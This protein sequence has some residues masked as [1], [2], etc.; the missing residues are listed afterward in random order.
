MDRFLATGETTILNRRIELT[1]MRA[2][3]TLFPVELAIVPIEIH[4]APVFTA[5][6]RDISDLK[7]S[8]EILKE[9]AMRYRQLV[10]L[11]PEA[12][13][14]HRNNRFVLLNQAAVRMLGAY[15]AS[16][17]LGRDVFDFI[18]PEHHAVC[19]ARVQTLGAG[20]TV[21]PLQE[22]VWLRLDGT[23]FDAEAAA[24]RVIYDD[25]IAIQAVV[26]DITE[27][28]RTEQLQSGQNR[29]LNMVATGVE[30]G[31]ILNDLALF[32]ESNTAG[33]RCSISLASSRGASLTIAAAPSLS[34][35]CVRTMDCVPIAPASGVCG[36]AAFSSEPVIVTDIA[37]SPLSAAGRRAALDSGLKG[38]ASW[39][40]SGKSGK[41][42]GTIALYFRDMREPSAKELELVDICLKLAAI[43]IESR[44]AEDRIRYL[45][46][47]DGLTALPNRFLFKEFLDQ[48]LRNAQRCG[49]KFAVLFVDLDKFKAINDTLGHDAGDLVLKEI[50]SRLRRCVRQTD[51]VARMGGDEFYV[52]I[53]HLEDGGDAADI[54]QKLLEEASR[55]IRIGQQECKLSASIGIGIYPEDGTTAQMLLKNADHAMYNAKNLGKDAFR[56][57]SEATRD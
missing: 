9:N 4:G 55:P 57:F 35:A 33:S 46:H 42:L 50:A 15:D 48:A 41:V 34:D 10:E 27:R 20:L 54:A 2:D 19:R 30:L 12:I 14:V 43:A 49:T 23:S 32:V 11:S 29:I 26:R 56:F 6:I 37:T 16:E 22:Q 38:C 47:Y 39:P 25:G 31:R 40:I 28:K 3:G 51:K 18:H 8:Q 53:D 13:F 1:A 44:E 45:A 36:T 5:F 21:A 17:L 24:T 52:L 7:H